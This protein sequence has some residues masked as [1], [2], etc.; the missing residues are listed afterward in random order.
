MLIKIVT[1]NIDLADSTKETI[2][3]RL[4]DK[5]SKFFK[6]DVTATVTIN[7]QKNNLKTVEVS[8]PFDLAMLRGEESSESI[9]KAINLVV[10]KLERQIRKQKTK[11]SRRNH[12]SSLKIEELMGTLGSVIPEIEEEENKIVKRK[13]FEVR[14]MYSDEAILEI[15]LIGHNFFVFRNADTEKVNVLYKRKDGNYGLIEPEF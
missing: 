6:D 7:G 13:K 4:E 2:K 3:E 9:T 5:L 8:I 15:E 11:L 10:E 1:R 12:S 14:M